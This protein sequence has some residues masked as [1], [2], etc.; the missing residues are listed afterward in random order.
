[1]ADDKP[2]DA[3]AAAQP[4]NDEK[5]TLDSLLADWESGDSKKEASTNAPDPDVTDRLAALEGELTQKI[6]D[7]EIVPL[8]KGDLDVPDKVVRGYLAESAVENPKLND[9][10]RDRHANKAKFQEALN[11]VRDEFQK[12]MSVL[13]PKAAPKDNS[14]AAAVAA[15]RETPPADNS[16]E[17]M[18]FSSMSDQKFAQTKRA[19]FK[20]FQ[21]GQLK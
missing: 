20:A 8:I 16:F 2:S 21:A 14:L 1:M 11:S 6:I 12:E 19:V 10:F 9:L 15:A 17:G 5:P 13:K 3:A 7:T 4:E 18:D